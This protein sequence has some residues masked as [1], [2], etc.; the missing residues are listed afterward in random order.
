MKI[1]KIIANFKNKLVELY[2][3]NK[4][5]FFAGV[6]C[7]LLVALGLVLPKFVDNKKETV[8]ISESVSGSEI[9]SYERQ[10]EQK[11]K[12]MLTNFLGEVANVLVLA[13]ESPIYN[14]LSQK[15]T[16]SSKNDKTENVV[17]KEEIV[18]EKNGSSQSP[19]LISVK[20][21]KIRGVLISV[22][23]IDAST[24]LSIQNSVAGVL[25]IEPASIFI[26]QDR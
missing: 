16:T 24:K 18:F 23:K 13:E 20:Y 4:R 14:Y 25:N 3:K 22:K 10:L 12:V 5:L 7:V 17:E 11:L 21:P 9:S 15:E 1:S 26:L 6:A 8:T 2:G 19:I